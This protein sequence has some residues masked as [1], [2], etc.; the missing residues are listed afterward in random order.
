MVQEH[1]GCI[2]SEQVKEI[3]W[4]EEA[5]EEVV[6]AMRFHWFSHLTLKEYEHIPKKLLFGWLPQC[7]QAGGSKQ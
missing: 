4:M 2:N 1:A 6:A 5:L 3:F 7:Q